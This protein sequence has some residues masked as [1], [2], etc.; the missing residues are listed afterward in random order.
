MR[1]IL[2]FALVG[3]TFVAPVWAQVCVPPPS[4]I[5]A[6]LPGDG[7]AN[8]IIGGNNGTLEAGVTFAP[9]EVGQAFKF[10]GLDGGGGIDLGNVSAFDFTPSSSFTI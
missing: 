7:N 1:N 6:W 9:G 5:V 3:L 2:W 4:G 8:D 10:N